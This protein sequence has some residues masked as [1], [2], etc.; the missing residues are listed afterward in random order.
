MADDWQA[1][2]LCAGVSWFNNRDYADEA[3][4]LCNDGPCPVRRECWQA[5]QG[6][7]NFDGIAG[8][9]VWRQRY[10]D[11]P[12][13]LEWSE[14]DMRRAHAAFL[15]RGDRTAWATEGERAFQ[16]WRKRVQRAAKK[17][18]AA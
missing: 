18:A 16:S 11:A 10:T 3:L 8:G 7:K 17:E 9:Q 2:A 13:F 14:P 5:A 1:R 6:D 4:A 12:L 15:T